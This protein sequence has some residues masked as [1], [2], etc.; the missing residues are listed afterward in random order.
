M[1]KRIS[2]RVRI[3]L[4]LA[5]LVFITL[6]GALVTVWYTYRMEGLLTHI[7]AKNVA[8]FQAA[9]ALRTA[10]VNQ[11]GFVSYYFMDG[12]PDWLRRLGEYRQIFKERLREVRTLAETEHE[13]G[14]I[15]R[16]DTE[17]TQ[18]ITGKDQVIAH[19]KAGQ[20]KAGTRL[21]TEV[22][23]NFFKTLELCEE[24]KDIHKKR[25]TVARDKSHAQARK[26]RIIAGTAILVVIVLGLLLLFVLVTQILGPVRRMALEA[27]REG[28]PAEP[29]DEVKA[30]SRSV[31]GL[32][33]DMDQ[34]QEELEKSREHLLQAEKM[35]LVGKLAAGVSHSVRN[36]LT[37]VKMRLFSLGRT[38]DLSA[39]EKEDF[40]VISEEIGQID[41]IVQNFLEFSR[42]PRLKM[43][44]VSPSDVV[45]LALQLLEH[46]LKS[47]N[48]NT[49]LKRKH[50][51]P[52][53]QADPEQLKEVL[54]N[55]VVNACE[56]MEG[57]GS[58]LIHEE[59]SFA[60]PLGRVVVIRL[61]DSGPGIPEEIRDKIFEPFFT[62][63]EEGSGLGLSIANRI[64]EEHNGWLD[65]ASKEGEG[66]TFVI[67]LP[68]NP[69]K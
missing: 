51:L 13:K 8:A 1:W 49:E 67:T 56:T 7:I 22:R 11:K 62:T 2:L 43:Q 26:L 47:Y 57:G 46:R 29:R 28:A 30:L 21:H 63:K 9:E 33:E 25:I 48:V 16:I 6:T 18:Y 27:D 68:I 50:P 54:V 12:D 17:Y 36:P 64:V 19:Y 38:L 59:E 20:R 53:I 23:N 10:L 3:Y 34:T 55:I 4:I 14:A 37:S 32:I 42:P 35:A 58:I 69:V 60:E 5:A 45:D 61:T 41:T 15:D 52:E 66:S 31:R 39:T 40:E 44:N 65:L 24:Y